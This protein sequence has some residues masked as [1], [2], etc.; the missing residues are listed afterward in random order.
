V[1]AGFSGAEVILCVDDE[2]ILLLALK[3]ELAR[4]FGGR[5]AIE[6]ALSA[7]DARARI[8]SLEAGGSR[9]SLVICDWNM[10]G[11]KGTDFLRALR[12]SRPAIASIL[13]TGQEEDATLRFAA[14]EAGSSACL[15]KPLRYEELCAAIESCL[16]LPR[17][18]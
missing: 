14:A 10:P 4:R 13:L 16:T 5:C 3:R 11:Q 17:R 8:E 18:T 6:T 12:A 1:P 2:A 7:E 15:Q 9:V